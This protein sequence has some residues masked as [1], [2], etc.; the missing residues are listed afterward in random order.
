MRENSNGA[1]SPP[2]C[3]ALGRAPRLDDQAVQ[4]ARLGASRSTSCPIEDASRA[5]SVGGPSG[6]NSYRKPLKTPPTCRVS[7]AVEQRFCKPLVGGSIPSPG[8]ACTPDLSG[9]LE[10]VEGQ[11]RC[12][13]TGQLEPR[14]G[15]AEIENT[16]PTENREVIERMASSRGA[17]P[18]RPATPRTTSI[19]KAGCD[20]CDSSRAFGGR[21]HQPD[22]PPEAEPSTNEERVTCPK[23]D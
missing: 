22:S 14:R 3:R 2:A 11:H 8:T 4:A 9:I 5:Q 10:A 13:V 19:L 6:G 21:R 15:I 17:I 1:S 16:T 18:I 20:L 7:S 23:S 12:E